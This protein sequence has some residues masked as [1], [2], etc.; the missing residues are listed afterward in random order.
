MSVVSHH[1][2]FL[3]I[4]A[5]QHYGLIEGPTTPVPAGMVNSVARNMNLYDNKSHDLI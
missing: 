1:H 5:E 4:F 3:K 2:G